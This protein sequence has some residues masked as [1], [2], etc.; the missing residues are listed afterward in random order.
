MKDPVLYETALVTQMEEAAVLEYSTTS[1][2]SLEDIKAF[3]LAT[4]Q[5]P[6]PKLAGP[7][8]QYGVAAITKTIIHPNNNYL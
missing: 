6:E 2:I 8:K 1:N 4:G 5:L 7:I 3:Y